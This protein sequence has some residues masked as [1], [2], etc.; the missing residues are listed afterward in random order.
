M[1]LYLSERFGLE[2]AD[3]E[4]W[5]GLAF[6]AAPFAAAFCGPFWGAL[7]DRV[8]R[9]L[10]AVR[11]IF[12]IAA[13]SLLL[14][15]AR[16][17]LEFVLLRGVQGLLSGYMAPALSLVSVSV[18]AGLQS[19][20]VGRLHSGFAVGL[21]SGPVA[22]AQIAAT[23]GREAVFW[24][25]AVMATIGFG[26]ILVFAREDRDRL[27]V[28]GGQGLRLFGALV[29]FLRRPVVGPLLATLAL[30]RFGQQLVDPFLPLWFEEI[31]LLDFLPSLPSGSQTEASGA[32]ASA[33]A[34]LAVQALGLMLF[35][36]RWGRLGERFGPLRVLAVAT[37]VQGLAMGLSALFPTPAAF[38]AVRVLYAIALAAT[39][40]LGLSAV[41]RRVEP[42]SRSLAFGC[43][44]SCFHA[45]MFCGPVVGGLAAASVSLRGLFVLSGVT[46]LFASVAMVLVRRR[47][48]ELT[49]AST[50]QSSPRAPDV[51]SDPSSG[52]RSRVPDRRRRKPGRTP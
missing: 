46:L 44:Q 12:G 40:T 33:A 11:A 6:A 47:G 35:A 17:P 21:L 32:D 20:V 5:T 43:V 25:T 14:P 49:Q 22:G 37:V 19:Q 26:S 52:N 31:G 29:G 2:G 8:G 18:P 16:S 34:I 24:F 23:L 1:P 15:F 3:L 36:S 30:L 39:F 9:K 10:M 27:N 28:S 45:G 48:M 50:S 51:S 4:R 13:I 38:F 7:G 41:A 42:E